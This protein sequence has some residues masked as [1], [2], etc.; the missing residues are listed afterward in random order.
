MKEFADE[1]S[2]PFTDILNSS[3]SEGVVR[4]QWKKAIGVPIPKQQPQSMDKLRPVFFTSICA[5]VAEGF[6]TNWI[7]EDIYDEIDTLQFGNVKGVS[8]AHSFSHSFLFQG[9]ERSHNVGTVV[10]LQTSRRRLI[11][12]TTPF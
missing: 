12:L 10:L 5:K 4:V 3:Y 7:L 6:I 2:V 1:L 11:L 9:A 8:T